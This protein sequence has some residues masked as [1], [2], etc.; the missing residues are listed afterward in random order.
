MREF[1]AALRFKSSDCIAIA[2]LLVVWCFALLPVLSSGYFGDD[3]INSYAKG[4]RLF[5]GQTLFE[6]TSYYFNSWVDTQGRFFPLAWYVYWC[7]EAFDTLFLYKFVTV[8][9]VIACSFTFVY[10]VFRLTRDVNLALCA[11]LLLG[12]IFQLRIYHDPIL[13]F[14]CLLQFVVIQTLFSLICLLWYFEENKRYFLVF[15]LLFYACSLLTYE[16]TY[17]FF[18]LP[19][20]LGWEFLRSFKKAA[21]IA[22]PYFLLSLLC[23]AVSIYLRSKAPSIDPT[24]QIHLNPLIYLKTL[25]KQTISSLPFI[26]YLRDPL[27]ISTYNPVLILKHIDLPGLLGALSFGAFF[28]P[29]LNRLKKIDQLPHFLWLGLGFMVLPAVMISL[30]AK[31]QRMHTGEGYLPVFVQYFG[32]SL[33][34][35]YCILWVLAK[36]N[37]E[38]LKKRIILGFTVIFSIVFL[39]NSQ[40]NWK[41]VNAINQVY[42]YPRQ[43]FEN[44]LRNGFL[45]DVSEHSALIIKNANSWD[46]KYFVYQHSNKRVNVIAPTEINQFLANS[47]AQMPGEKGP[48]IYVMKYGSKSLEDG[49]VM[50]GKLVQ[51]LRSH[52]ADTPA[53][54]VSHLKVYFADSAG[55]YAQAVPSVV[56]GDAF[57]FALSA[58]K[59]GR[60][61]SQ[62][63]VPLNGKHLDFNVLT[64]SD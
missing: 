47:V 58:I 9:S 35:L 10:F 27:H 48:D 59:T 12:V 18:L 57:K 7:F 61:F 36:A 40:N 53:L 34:V 24:Y 16:I 37:T 28:Y 22:A 49:Y 6:L 21:F 51:P 42:L 64:I 62:A 52:N 2:G 54:F 56:D 41:V 60:G 8:L 45:A 29:V 50:L 44:S 63:E 4:V 13:S 20:I 15:S 23:I 31:H 11:G 17:I 55:K 46:S 3:S 33:I 38:L 32:A 25:Y 5:N 1:I 19:F 14:H 30:S 43:V 39:I 26:Y